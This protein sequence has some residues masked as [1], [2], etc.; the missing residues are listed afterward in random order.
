VTAAGQYLTPDMNGQTIDP[1]SRGVAKSFTLVAEDV[2]ADLSSVTVKW[3]IDGTQYE[4]SMD[5]SNPGQT[6][7]VKHT[8][9]NVKEKAQVRVYVKDKDMVA[10]PSTPNFMFYVPVSE[11]SPPSISNV[12]AQ[13]RLPWNGLVDVDYEV[14]G[15]TD[16]LAV[17]ISFAEQG[18][19]GRHWTATN[20]LAGAEPT[21]NQGRNRAT[22]DTNAAGV[23]N[24]VAAEVTAKVEL[25]REE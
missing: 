6:L 12:V 17:R 14:G 4:E 15:N 2:A 19:A 3:I 10:Y 18:G 5:P 1:V 25:V 21:L 7:A 20:F 24:V 22:W 23:T 8:F 16:G 9:A 11:K 13:Q